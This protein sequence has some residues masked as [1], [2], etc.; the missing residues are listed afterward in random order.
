MVI[1]YLY[2]PGLILPLLLATYC[3][4]NPKRKYKEITSSPFSL[5]MPPLAIPQSPAAAPPPVSSSLQWTV[6]KAW[7]E[8]P[9][10]GMR[11]ATFKIQSRQ[12]KGECK[13]LSFMGPA[14]GPE[15]NVRRWLSQQNLS[16]TDPEL[17]SFIAESKKLKSLSGIPILLMDFTP[18]LSDQKA[19]GI[20]AAIA[21]L[22]NQTVFLKMTGSKAMLLS[23]KEKFISLCRSL[24]KAT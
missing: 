20:I 24:R 14:G 17:K 1:K 15:A 5:K 21:S 16:L 22:K 10:R 6:P 4:K 2:L 9:A 13:I 12:G 19:S 3:N 7:E 11:L 8:L 23:H 18:L